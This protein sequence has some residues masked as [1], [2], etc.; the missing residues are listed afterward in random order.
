MGQLILLVFLVFGVG[1]APHA[2]DNERVQAWMTSGPMHFMPFV[3]RFENLQESAICIFDARGP[4]LM[5]YRRGDEYQ[6]LS[7]PEYKSALERI[8]RQ[9]H[10][11]SIWA[12]W[13]ADPCA[14]PGV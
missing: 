2:H 8:E 6:H 11:P 4:L 13:W 14:Q 12:C 5:N 9:W 1:E 3:E 10:P 7:C